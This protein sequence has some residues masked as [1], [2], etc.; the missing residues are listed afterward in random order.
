[1]QRFYN[2]PV[3]SQRQV[4]TQFSLVKLGKNTRGVESAF[5]P[6]CNEL[7]TGIHKDE[8][9]AGF[10]ESDTTCKHFADFI[11]GDKSSITILFNGWSSDLQNEES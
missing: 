9:K 5:C 4:K 8:I 3:Q 6:F 1:M 11:M 2:L 7:N 10:V